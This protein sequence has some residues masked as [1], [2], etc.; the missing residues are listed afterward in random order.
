MKSADA[1]NIPAVLYED[2]HLLALN[3]P[4]GLP[5]QPDDSGDPS[6]VD[7]GKD[8][9]RAKYAKPGNIYLALLHRLDRPTSGIV[10]L[11]KTDKAAKRMAERFR[12]REVEKTYYALVEGADSLADEGGAEDRL[13][14]SGSGG[15]RIARGA[16]GAKAKR[17]LLSWRVLAREAG[18][19]ALLEIALHTG[20]KH[21]IRCQLAA[22]GAPVVGD[23]RYGPKGAPARPDPVAGGRAILLHAGRVAFSHPVRGERL[24]LSAPPPDVWKLYGKTA[25]A[26]P[27]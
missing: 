14:A 19:R 10:L 7:W 5:S 13:E 8:W 9:L 12:L 23:F 20:V 15:M 22:R 26:P 24:A 16:A 18:G 17:A 1:G 11:A 4:A 27:L 25:G 21:Q 2:N 6:L 3:K